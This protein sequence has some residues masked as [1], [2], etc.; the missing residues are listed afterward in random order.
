M[1]SWADDGFSACAAVKSSS[2]TCF[3]LNLQSPV[4]WEAVLPD[5]PRVGPLAAGA[6]GGAGLWWAPG[7]GLLG[8]P[9][10]SPDGD[11]SEEAVKGQHF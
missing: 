6:L 3:R 9:L 11:W 10:G 8:P 4:Q 5:L 2:L 7:Q 1:A